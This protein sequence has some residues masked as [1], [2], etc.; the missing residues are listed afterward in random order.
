MGGAEDAAL[1]DARVEELLGVDLHAEAA[2]HGEHRL[3][4]HGRGRVVAGAVEAGDEAVSDELVLAR[5]ADLGE[6]VAAR[7]ALYV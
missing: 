5:A 6:A 1:G 2:Q 3:R 7:K 4:G